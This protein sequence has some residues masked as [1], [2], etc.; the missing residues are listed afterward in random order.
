MRSRSDRLRCLPCVAQGAVAGVGAGGSGLQPDAAGSSRSATAGEPRRLARSGWQPGRPPGGPRPPLRCAGR[1]GRRFR[2]AGFTAPPPARTI[3][4]PVH[5]AIRGRLAIGRCQP[6]DQCRRVPGRVAPSQIPASPV[7]GPVAG[8]VPAR[9]PQ[10]IP[11]ATGRDRDRHQP[12]DSFPAAPGHRLLA[13]PPGST[14]QYWLHR[15]DR[16]PGSG[17][18]QS[19]RRGFGSGA[20]SAATCAA[21]Q[22]EAN[23]TA[24]GE[25]RSP[26]QPGEREGRSGWAS[27]WRGCRRVSRD[28]KSATLI[29]RNTCRSSERMS[30]RDSS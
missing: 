19:W 18:L 24:L 28:R 4:V 25:P 5:A 8:S 2:I 14:G 13:R 11:G 1:A 10:A 6:G 20:R 27:R 30:R 17:R 12:A 9:A 29:I 15:S 23:Y 26:P 16:M 7:T 22:V 3:R 21:S